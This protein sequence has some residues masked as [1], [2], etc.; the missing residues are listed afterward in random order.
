MPTIQ[1]LRQASEQCRELAATMPDL[2][3]RRRLVTHALKLAEDAEAIERG[4]RPFTAA[5]YPLNE[6]YD[7]VSGASP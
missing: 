7:A 6:P 5:L 1:E 4:A 3:L 2:L